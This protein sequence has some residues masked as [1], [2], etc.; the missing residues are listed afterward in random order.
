M[1][2][3][4]VFV[5]RQENSS[6]SK[7]Q[8]TDRS[9]ASNL[10]EL[11]RQQGASA[12]YTGM[13]GALFLGAGIWNGE[14]DGEGRNKPGVDT[15]H[16][17]AVTARYTALGKM[18]A[19][20]EG[21]INGTEDA[22]LNFGVAYA[23]GEIEDE[24][25]KSD[26]HSLSADATFKYQGFS[27]HSEFFY[28]IIDTDGD[29]EEVEPLAFYVQSGYFIVPQ[30]FEVAARYAFA[31]CDDGAYG[32]GLCSGNDK[33][34][35]ATAGLN[36]FFWKH[37]LKAQLNWEWT[38]GELVDESADDEDTHRIVFQMSSYF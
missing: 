20:E 14:S 38:R 2:Q 8:F 29:S 21:D 19:M 34:H 36:Y 7:L 27:V 18:D 6:S 1:G 3:Y 28:R 17:G 4:K 24:G 12:R 35:Q 31:D 16:T 32:T 25:A 15:R 5:S 13:D 10:F 33:V 26:K 37:S 22:A 11:G 30:K 9:V 23:Y